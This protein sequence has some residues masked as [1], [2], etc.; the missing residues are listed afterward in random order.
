MSEYGIC[1]LLLKCA[2]V[3][4]LFSSWEIRAELWYVHGVGFL[5]VES[6]ITLN[7]AIILKQDYNN[8]ILHSSAN[9]I[10][11]ENCVQVFR[12]QSIITLLV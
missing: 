9:Q 12:V 1:H 6:L 10:I 11:T 5:T 4:T 7:V 3:Y 2:S 8:S